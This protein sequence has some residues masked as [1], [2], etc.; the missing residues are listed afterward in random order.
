ML[1]QHISQF[2]LVVFISASE[3]AAFPS[4]PLADEGADV[5][6]FGYGGAAHQAQLHDAPVAGYAVEIALDVG[7]ADEIDDLDGDGRSV[8]G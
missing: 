8:L 2:A 6:T 3:A 5:Y 7:S 4:H 1:A